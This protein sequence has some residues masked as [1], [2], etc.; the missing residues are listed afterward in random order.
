MAK[1]N[2]RLRTGKN[3]HLVFAR[4]FT[5]QLAEVRDALDTVP[6]DDPRWDVVAEM[7]TGL[8]MERDG[9][10]TRMKYR[11][12]TR[13]GILARTALQASSNVDGER[14][15][16]SLPQSDELLHEIEI[17][18]FTLNVFSQVRLNQPQTF[19]EA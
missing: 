9:S 15:L 10:A 3:R 11:G 14:V 5:L 7:A 12:H 13:R 1:G 6:I 16:Q 19:A 2:E 8:A 17:P 4:Q 18:D